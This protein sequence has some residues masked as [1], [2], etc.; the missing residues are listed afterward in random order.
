MRQDDKKAWGGEVKKRNIIKAN[1][2]SVVLV[3]GA[4]LPMLHF[5]SNPNFKKINAGTFVLV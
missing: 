4:D 3:K 2:K 5:Y 1:I